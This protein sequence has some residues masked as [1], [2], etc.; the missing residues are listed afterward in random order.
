MRQKE[1]IA[2][3]STLLKD[4]R[5]VI[6]VDW[7]TN[8]EQL[9]VHHDRH[10]LS[11][12]EGMSKDQHPEFRIVKAASDENIQ[13]PNQVPP[14]AATHNF[15]FTPKTM[16]RIKEMANHGDFHGKGSCEASYVS[17]IDAITALF[18]VLI[19]RARDAED[20]SDQGNGYEV[21]EPERSRSSDVPLTDEQRSVYR[22][23]KREGINI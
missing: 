1:L 7:Q 8:E 12:A 11:H 2:V 21:D 5:L 18:T 15:H 13:L 3:K 6:G 23:E 20:D 9:V 19:S 16:K 22:Q 4:G 14:A 10:L 17:T